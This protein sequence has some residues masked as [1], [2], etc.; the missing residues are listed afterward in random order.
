MKWRVELLGVTGNQ[1]LVRDVLG[2]LSIFIIEEEGGSFLVSEQFETFNTPAEV[3]AYASRIQSI[4]KKVREYDTEIEVDFSMGSVVKE[5]ADGMR[6]KHH[7]LVVSDTIHMHSVTHVACL[8]VEPA[9][10]ISEEERK[11]LEAERRE[12]E[13]QQLRAKAVSRIVAAV[14]DDRALTVQRLLHA[15]LKPQQLGHIADLIKDDL[16]DLTKLASKSQWSRFY[17]SINHPDVFGKE[18]RHIVSS[19]DPPPKPMGLDEA[20]AFIRGLA[21]KWLSLKA[22]LH[23]DA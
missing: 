3:H 4:V 22:G 8:K 21:D 14:N 15:D 13:Y 5:N 2:E 9:A 1:R 17:R 6:R 18:A 7:F 12:Q 11:R 10:H 19:Q 20:R 23:G 16:G